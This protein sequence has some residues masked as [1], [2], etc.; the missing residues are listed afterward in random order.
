[1]CDKDPFCDCHDPLT[2]AEFVSKIFDEAM[3]QPG[4]ESTNG[5][6][7]VGSI[8]SLTIIIRR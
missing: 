6:S 3:A 5:Y 8:F 4:A 7:L 2:H 1:M